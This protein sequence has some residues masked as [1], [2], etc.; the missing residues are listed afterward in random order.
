M[1]LNPWAI[2]LSQAEFNAIK[3]KIADRKAKRLEKGLALGL[4]K[5]VA[6]SK[7]APGRAIWPRKSKRTP[8]Q[9]LRDR[10]DH[11]WSVLIRRRDNKLYAGICVICRR[12]PISVAYHIVPR[13][14]DAT[15]WDTENG[16]GACYPCNRGEQM[17]RH[18]YRRKHIAIFGLEKI[19]RLD[20]KSA[21]TARFS[22]ADLEEIEAN[23]K[24]LIQTGAYK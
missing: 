1:I 14:D 12:R 18:R 24:R 22:M 23:I 5:P 9:N 16:C 6:A 3:R 7:D 19:E 2:R 4:R 10:L 15:R 20:A 13:G 11:L 8:R 17:N 21:T